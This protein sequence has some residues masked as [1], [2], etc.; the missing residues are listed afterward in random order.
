MDFY[1]I[2]AGNFQANIETIS[3]C[4][5]DLAPQA[6]GIGMADMREQARA[7]VAECLQVD[8]TRL[9]CALDCPDLPPKP[10]AGRPRPWTAQRATPATG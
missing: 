5:D 10:T 8:P 1:Q 7:A 3:L 9:V 2:I 4:V 6:I